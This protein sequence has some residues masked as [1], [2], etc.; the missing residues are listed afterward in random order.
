MSEW[1]IY[2]F[3]SLITSIWMY[4]IFTWSFISA[5]THWN[6]LENTVKLQ[7][8]QTM[9]TF[10]NSWYCGFY[11]AENAAQKL[12]QNSRCEPGLK[13]E[14]VWGNGSWFQ[15]ILHKYCNLVWQLQC[16]LFSQFTCCQFSF[17]STHVFLTVIFM[18][19]QWHS[20]HT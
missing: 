12:H 17:F 5:G 18:G 15:A 11:V 9:F 20:L 13:M 8:L 16:Q 1:K 3:I 7:L 14:K 2:F 10:Y 6:S 4:L 19:G